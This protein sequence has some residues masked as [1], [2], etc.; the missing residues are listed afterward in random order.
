MDYLYNEVISPWARAKDP[1]VRDCAAIALGPPA[2]DRQLRSTTRQL[3]AN[4]A[5]EDSPWQLRATAARAYGLAIGPSTPTSALRALARLSEESAEDFDVV[6]AISNSY[7]EL[8]LNGTT[9]LSVRVI[10]EV[11][12][13][14]A[15]RKRPLQAAGRLTL[16]GLSTLRG[17]PPDMEG[18]KRRL[19]SW[20]TLLLLAL[21]NEAIAESAAH[22][23]QLSLH[24][25][26]IGDLV[27]AS[28]D[29]WAEEAEAVSE[30]RTRFVLFLQWITTD[31]RSYQ[32]VLRRAQAWSGRDGKAPRTG[33]SVIEAQR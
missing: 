6:A 21:A 28:L 17:A 16:L 13:L 15:D 3:V 4:W 23:W 20:P 30:L 1:D 25:P 29:A 31:T 11:E 9:A 7:C 18:G 12:R 2:D 5:D 10:S 14:A 26:E 27:T 22:L 8:V 33:R 24:D 19:D 32:A